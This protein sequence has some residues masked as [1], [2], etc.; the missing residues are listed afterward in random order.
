MNEESPTYSGRS[1]LERCEFLHIPYV[2]YEIFYNLMFYCLETK[3]DIHRNKI[4]FV[5]KKTHKKIQK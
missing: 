5:Y 3:L 2:S 4:K 1:K